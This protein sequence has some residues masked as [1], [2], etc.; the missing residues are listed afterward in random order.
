[1]SERNLIFLGPPGAGKGTQAKQLALLWGIPQISTGDMLRE[2]RRAGT[3]L[4]RQV[5]SVMDTGG[6]VSDSLV[7]ALVEERLQRRDAQQGFILDGF[8]RTLI[9]AEALDKFLARLGRVPALVVFFIV[10]RRQLVERLGGRLSC[11][12]DGSSYHIQMN[13][14]CV[15]GICNICGGLLIERPDDRPEAILRRLETYEKDT[16]PVVEYY[17]AN[18]ALRHVDGI[19]APEEILE[20]IIH[21]LT[22]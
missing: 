22:V 18:K 7:V 14:P 6:L 11:P 9:Q 19:G 12:Q 3:E 20:R 4:G 1:M 16:I 10:E 13:P 2:A 21:T 5:A 17:I 15:A 8:P